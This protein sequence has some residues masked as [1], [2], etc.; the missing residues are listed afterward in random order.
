MIG[1]WEWLIWLCQYIRD[2]ASSL[3]YKLSLLHTGHNAFRSA[4]NID[5]K[6]GRTPLPIESTK[7][8]KESAVI[9]TKKARSPFS[10]LPKPDERQWDDH[11]SAIIS[12]FYYPFPQKSAKCPEKVRS[13]PPLSHQIRGT[14]K[15]GYETAARGGTGGVRDLANPTQIPHIHTD[16][17]GGDQW[18][19]NAP[20]SVWEICI[21][22]ITAA[23]PQRR[24]LLSS[25]ERDFIEPHALFEYKP[26]LISLVKRPLFVYMYILFS[27]FNSGLFIVHV[28]SFH[29]RLR[30]WR[31]TIVLESL[32]KMGLK[33]SF[34]IWIW[35][36]SI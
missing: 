31:I 8:S 36:F 25:H 11:H 29:F 2:W 15:M 1:W 21:P 34:A 27:Y 35:T 33:I 4:G 14:A 26:P 12:S 6:E 13:A 22:L 24:S 19:G 9:S 7:R 20:F 16:G 5:P 32:I 18:C 23:K 3:I 10:S 30:R 17:G 28:L